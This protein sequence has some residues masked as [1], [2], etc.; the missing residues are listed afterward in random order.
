MCDKHVYRHT[1]VAT[2]ENGNFDPLIESIPQFEEGVVML[3]SCA[4]QCVNEGLQG[5]C[6][7]VRYSLSD[8]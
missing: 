1:A 8:L 6:N 5:D 7:C 3:E 2:G 4:V